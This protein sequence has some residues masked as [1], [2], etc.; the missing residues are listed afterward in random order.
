MPNTTPVCTRAAHKPTWL[1]SGGF[2]ILLAGAVTAAGGRLPLR[3]AAVRD[4]LSLLGR[5]RPA[6]RRAERGPAGRGTGGGAPAPRRRRGL[7]AASR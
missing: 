6:G 2:L 4:Q 1:L 7:T 5:W 3:L